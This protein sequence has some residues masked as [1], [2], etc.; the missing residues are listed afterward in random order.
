MDVKQTILAA[1]VLTLTAALYGAEI[2]QFGAGEMEKPGRTFYLSPKGNDKND[3]KTPETAWRSLNKVK[4]GVSLRAGD[5]LLLDEG[6]YRGNMAFNVKDRTIGYS[7]QCGKP[8]APIRIA[9]MPGKNAVLT[10]AD[11]LPNPKQPVE[12]RVYEFPLKKAPLYNTV[13]ESPSD[14]QLQQVFVPEIVKEIPGTYYFDKAAGRLLVHYAAEGQKGIRVARDR[15]AIRIQGSWFIVENL[16]FK[17]YY[18]A[19]YARMNMP[20]DKNVAEHITIRNC[21]F[22]N[23]YKN[24]IVIDGASFSLITKNVG[25]QNGE[26]GTVMMMDRGHDNLYT[27]NWLGPGPLTLRQRK[28]YEYN[29]A[30]NQY[31]GWGKNSVRNYVIG[32]VLEDKLSFRWKPQAIDARFEDNMCYGR[33]YA[34]SPA[35]PVTILRNWFGGTVTQLGIGDLWKDIPKGS[36][37]VF[38]DNVRDKKDFKPENPI[39][40]E[41]E[42]LRMKPPKVVFPKVTFKDVQ[43]KFIGPDSAAICWTTPECDG[44]GSI[45]I[46]EKGE[47]KEKRLWS[48]RQGVRHAIGVNGLKPDTEYE[49]RLIFAGRRSGQWTG[50]KQHSRSF[51]TAKTARAPQVL[52]V[53][54]GKMTL[55]EAALAAIP[56]DTVKLLPGKH[57][58]QFIPIRSGTAE[59][60]IMLKGEPGAV[61]DGQLFHAPLIDLS[62]KSNFV[63]DGIRFERPESTARRG[64][65]VVA[66]GS[67]II[68]R[69]CRSDVPDNQWQAGPVIRGLGC[70]NIQFINNICKGGDYMVQLG[71]KNITVSHNTIIDATMFSTDFWHVGDLTVTDNIFYR[72]CIPVKRNTALRFSDVKGK[73][74]SDRNVFWSPVEKHPVGGMICNIRS[75]ILKSSKTLEEWQQVSGMDQNSIHADPMFVDYKNGDFRLKEGSPAKG[76]GATLP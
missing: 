74:V 31:G 9:G 49:Y 22:F 29:F 70:R 14:I 67:N 8:G 26:Y 50:E 72:P 20:F 75:H 52:E 38:K 5:T 27:G 4:W 33:Y 15:N 36:P 19:I 37:M 63:I 65:I 64:V 6:E 41:A 48:A 24:G 66:R 28:P 46:R 10:G 55:E 56:G 54:P 62:G 40:F 71:G 11:F 32:N 34:E 44:Q 45:G 69:N 7:E 1:S 2:P 57:H 68:V 17:Y 53:G 16:T 35:R 51:R 30:L 21:K 47:T 59:K 42:K 23:N 13:M 61:V 60:P 76:K 39:V 18:E 3:G 43:V 73:I 58:G 25:L 12:G